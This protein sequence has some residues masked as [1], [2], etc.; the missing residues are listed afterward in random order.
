MGGFFDSPELHTYELGGLMMHW[1]ADKR[2]G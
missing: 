2:D 1:C